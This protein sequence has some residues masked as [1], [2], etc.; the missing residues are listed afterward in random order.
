M[1]E[2]FL[3]CDWGTSSFRLKL[4]SVPELKVIG[5]EHSGRGISTVFNEWEKKNETDQAARQTFYF[6]TISSHLDLLEKKLNIP[7]AHIPIALSGM[8]S[9]TIGI[10]DIPYTVVPFATDG[11]NLNT[12]VIKSTPGFPHDVLIISGAR[13]SDDVMRG[14]ETQLV[15]CVDEGVEGAATGK[16]ELFI[17]PGTH[18]KHITVKDNQVTAFTTYMT[19]E[20]FALLSGQSILHV[21]VKKP[22]ENQPLDSFKK[23]VEAA[24]TGNLLHNAFLV[25]TNDLFKKLSKEENFA[26][27]SGLVI[28]AELKDLKGTKNVVLCCNSNL[29]KYYSA[30]I[31]ILALDNARVF[32]AEKVDKSVIKGQ[33]KI[34]QNKGLNYG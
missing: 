1:T 2:Y 10:T 6:A 24:V 13:T 30:A 16:E 17:F 19:G 11:E 29:E 9:S 26:Y 25:R 4:I 5:E 33:F 34:L 22:M 20:F 15:G 21:A 28:G 8:A 12:R 18:S 3:S 14:E 23:G 31:E 32:P 27:L 7:L